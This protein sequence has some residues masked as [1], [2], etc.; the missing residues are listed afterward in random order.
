MPRGTPR[1]KEECGRP[2]PYGPFRRL[3]RLVCDQRTNEVLAPYSPRSSARGAGI[4]FQVIIDRASARRWIVVRRA[5]PSIH[6]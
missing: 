6:T 1:V 5:R 4:R 2:S 3:G